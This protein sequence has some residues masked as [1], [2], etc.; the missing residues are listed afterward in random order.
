MQLTGL[1][2]NVTRSAAIIAYRLLVLHGE[3]MMSRCGSSAR[4][5]RDLIVVRK[6]GL[7]MQWW[8]SH[9]VWSD[10]LT[11][12]SLDCFRVWRGRSTGYS[13][14]WCIE[15][16]VLQSILRWRCAVPWAWRTVPCAVSC[17]LCA[18]RCLRHCHVRCY[19]NWCF[20]ADLGRGS[21]HDG[22]RLLVLVG[23]WRRIDVVK[24]DKFASTII[25]RFILRHQRERTTKSSMRLYFV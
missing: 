8:W 16:R 4:K 7:L 2:R 11:G 18:D 5:Q 1:A 10:R 3:G 14:T 19:W 23:G 12:A 6:D 21:I 9:K 24:L 22:R 17:M 25:I 20:V 13:S 15:G